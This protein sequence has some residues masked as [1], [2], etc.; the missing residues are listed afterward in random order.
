MTYSE[1]L[2]E[3]NIEYDRPLTEKDV[4]YTCYLIECVSRLTLHRNKETTSKLG[5]GGIYH[6][7]CFIQQYQMLDPREASEEIIEDFNLDMGDFVITDISPQYFTG[8]P[9]EY[10][11]GLKYGELVLDTKTDNESYAEA[12]LR[13]YKNPIC[14]VIDD[15][16]CNAYEECR[17]NTKIAYEMGYFECQ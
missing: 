11:M 1:E 16:E 5:V 6:I 9:D 15:Y 12:I 4:T 3:C 10:R 7:M 8:I 14:G 2:E 17:H 13:V